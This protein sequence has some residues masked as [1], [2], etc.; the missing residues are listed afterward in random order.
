MIA[1]LFNQII[2]NKK[3]LLALY[4]PALAMLLLVVIANRLF[5]VPVAELMRDTTSLAGV[6]PWTGFISNVGVLFWCAAMTLSFSATAVLHP[7]NKETYRG[8]L[9]SSGA[10]TAFLMLDDFFV[11]HESFRDYLGF[12]E[13]AFFALYLL[14][15]GLYLFRYGRLILRTNFLFLGLAFAFLGA[16]MGLDNFQ[17]FIVAYIPY[18]FY[19]LIEDGLKL[20]GIISWFGYFA[21]L[22]SNLGQSHVSRKL[23]SE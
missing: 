20:V 4:L 8:F 5:N 12:P 13:K 22:F 11:L 21:L 6:A 14:F 3:L 19:Y 18:S 16:S 7:E 15:I 1:N 9:L 17:D 10:L 2:Q 23:L